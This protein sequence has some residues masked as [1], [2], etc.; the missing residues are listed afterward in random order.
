MLKNTEPI[1]NEDLTNKNAEEQ[2]NF[3]EKFSE[4]CSQLKDCL[5]S[6]W[7]SGFTTYACCAGHN[8]ELPFENG[9]RLA[10][11]PYVMFEVSSLK[12]DELNFL[13]KNILNLKHLTNNAVEVAVQIDNIAY[14]GK[15]R[16]S[17]SVYFVNKD[18]NLFKEVEKFV[19]QLNKKD[20]TA[21]E[22]VLTFEDKT[23]IEY[24]GELTEKLKELFKDID[25]MEIGS[26]LKCL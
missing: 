10:G 5:L 8:E 9:S 16:H 19:L 23:Y 17:L 6:L 14:F 21:P 2:E 1:L 22:S 3:A 4:D 18:V 20:F 25:I 11:N 26:E 7:K 15:E 12:E 13:L 24:V